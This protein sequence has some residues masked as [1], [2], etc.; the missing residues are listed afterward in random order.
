MAIVSCRE[1]IKIKVAVAPVSGTLV[2]CT[3]CPKQ[4]MFNVLVTGP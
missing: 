1:N 4:D 3:N 2:T